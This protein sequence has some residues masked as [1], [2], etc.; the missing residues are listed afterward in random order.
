MRI[1]KL[2]YAATAELD[3]IRGEV[4][5]MQQQL[6]SSEHQ[7]KVELGEKEKEFVTLKEVHEVHGNQS[8][9]KIKDSQAQVT[10]LELELEQ[11]RT[12]NRDM[13]L[14]IGNKTSDAKQLGEINNLVAGMELLHTEKAE[15]EEQ[16]AVKGDEALT[17]ELDG[18]NKCLASRAGVKEEIVSK[19]GDQQRVLQE[20]EGLLAQTKELELVV[21]SLRNQ[22][23]ELE[24][25]LRSKIE[26]N[27][28][29]LKDQINNLQQELESLNNQKADLEVQ[30]ERKNQAISDYVIEIE[31][32]KEEIIEENDQ[33]RE[34]NTGLQSQISQ[35]EMILKTRE[36]EL[37]TLTKNFEDNEKE[38]LSRVENLTMQI[39]NLLV[40]MGPLHNQKAQLEEHIVVKG[41]EESTQIKSLI[42]QIRTLQQ[43]LESLHSQK[44]ELEVQLEEGLLAQTKELESEVNSLKNQKGELEKDLRTKIDETGQLR[45]E[46]MGFEGQIFDL[47][48]TLVERGLEFNALGE[49]HA[50][51]ENETSSQLTALVTQLHNLQQELDSLQARRNELELQLER[52][53]QESLER[54]STFENEKI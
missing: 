41:D 8:S 29:N 11:L 49:K 4:S 39:N 15:L 42:D 37:L 23:S 20:N 19:T 17:Q 1:W 50:S 33:L 44:A 7:S 46:K 5:S 54:F 21:N 38:S 32:E 3:S 52:E 22:K 14:Q 10:G 48:K 47:E 36:Y 43:E 28:K 25:D 34:E 18:S 9:A 53:K 24:D 30:L 6:E 27:V 31:K 45:E 40:D 35:L 12:T 2:Q 51:L 13:E 16:I 26:E